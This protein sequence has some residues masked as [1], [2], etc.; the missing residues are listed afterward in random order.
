MKWSEHIYD[1]YVRVALDIKHPKFGILHI[2]KFQ[3]KKEEMMLLMEERNPNLKILKYN[4][5]YHT[6]VD[7]VHFPE[8]TFEE[9]GVTHK[10]AEFYTIY[11]DWTGY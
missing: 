1:G 3:R 6:I 11:V 5:D 4:S 7:M 8:N 2:D 9:K 10:V